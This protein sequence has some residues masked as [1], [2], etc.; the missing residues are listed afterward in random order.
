V[1]R[2]L[3]GAGG[4]VGVA[5]MGGVFRGAILRDQFKALVEQ[6]PATHCGPPLY[7]PAAGALLEAYRAAGLA[8]KLSNVPD[9]KR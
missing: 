9:V 6:E 7:A 8:P 5:H 1:R 4:N 2:Q 3:F